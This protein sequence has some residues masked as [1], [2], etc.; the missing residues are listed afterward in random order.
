MLNNSMQRNRKMVREQ[1]INCSMQNDKTDPQIATMLMNP[2]LS[3]TKADIIN[4]P[5]F[6]F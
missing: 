1:L 6:K 5:E 3:F 4:A 2:N